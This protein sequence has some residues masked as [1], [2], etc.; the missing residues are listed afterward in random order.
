MK[1][2]IAAMFILATSD[3]IATADS[4]MP[5]TA[6]NPHGFT[7]QFNMKNFVNGSWKGDVDFAI[8]ACPQ[9]S[10]FRLSGHAVLPINPKTGSDEG[11]FSIPGMSCDLYFANVPHNDMDSGDWRV[12]PM[13]RNGVKNGCASL[14]RGLGGVYSDVKY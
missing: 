6:R 8:S 14:P 5:E 12:T 10:C 3:N 1:Q 9:K 4:V 11:T 7:M 13:N 2:I